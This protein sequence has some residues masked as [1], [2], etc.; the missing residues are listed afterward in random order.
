MSDPQ[1]QGRKSLRLHIGGRVQG[2]FYRNWMIGEANRRNLDGWVRNLSDGTVEALVA[3][4]VTDVDALVRAC[5]EGPPAAEVDRVE[6]SPAPD[7]GPGGFT[8]A[9]SR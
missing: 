2:V 8:R 5:W 7:P 1:N 9:A 3:G 4:P 6:A